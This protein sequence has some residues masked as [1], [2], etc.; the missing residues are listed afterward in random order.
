MSDA[1]LRFLR[2]SEIVNPMFTTDVQYKRY[3]SDDVED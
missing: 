2:E 1:I 3:L